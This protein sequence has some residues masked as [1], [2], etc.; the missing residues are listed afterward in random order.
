MDS[1]LVL[2]QLDPAELPA[3]YKHQPQT[4]ILA[5]LSDISEELMQVQCV[6]PQ[7]CTVFY[8]ISVQPLTTWTAECFQ[9]EVVW[10][11]KAQGTT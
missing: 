4:T 7:S 8:W 11:V 9:D 2:Q 3:Y 1:R 10:I 6:G 5:H